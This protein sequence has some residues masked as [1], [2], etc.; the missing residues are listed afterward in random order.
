MSAYWNFSLRNFQFFR[1]SACNLLFVSQRYDAKELYN[2]NYFLGGTHG[3]GFSNYEDDKAASKTYLSKFIDI[4][5]EANIGE[6]SWILD[7]GAANGFF[8]SLCTARGLLAEGLEISQEAC[9]WAR[10][11][12]RAVTCSALEDFQTTR[13]YSAITAL[14][15]LE[16]THDP[17]MFLSKVREL[18]LDNGLF[19]VNVPNSGSLTARLSGTKWHA[20][21]PP[22][23]WF[24]F[25]RRSLRTLLEKNGFKVVKMKSISKSFTVS[26]IYL[27]VMN[28]P[29]ITSFL[30][31]ILSRLKFL[32]EGKIGKL[33]I[34][35][36]LYDNLFVIATKI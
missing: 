21:L 18:L 20:L 7:V 26:Y 19:F 29:Q 2:Q 25:D 5:E 11:L 6:N 32:N 36:P 8:V 35:L 31:R 12:G 10:R 30:K 27:T 13:R 22:E 17:I 14:D 15:V 3:F 4:I 34:F 33:K 28:S 9:D 16:H 24:Y 23:H 1:C